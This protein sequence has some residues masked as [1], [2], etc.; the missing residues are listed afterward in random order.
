MTGIKKWIKVIVLNVEG[1]FIFY[2]KC[3]KWLNF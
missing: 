1:K 2:S 3:G